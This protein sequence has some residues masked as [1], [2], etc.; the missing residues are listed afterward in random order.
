M[1]DSPLRDGREPSDPTPEQIRKRAAEVRSGWS[2]RVLKRRRVEDEPTW[3][4]P[5]V[6]MIEIVRE[7]NIRHQA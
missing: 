1:T 2:S 3:N 4:P 7:M 6:M 5:L